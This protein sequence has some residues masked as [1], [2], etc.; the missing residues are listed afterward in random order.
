MSFPLERFALMPR[1][2]ARACRTLYLSAPR[3]SSVSWVLFLSAILARVAF[4]SGR[5]HD[6]NNH[7]AAKLTRAQKTLTEKVSTICV[8]Y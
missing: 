6:Q 4:A 7:H 1:F 2:L 5:E 8:I 3:D